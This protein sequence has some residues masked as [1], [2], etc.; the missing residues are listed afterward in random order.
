MKP[1]RARLLRMAAVLLSVAFSSLAL[2][3]VDDDRKA[4]EINK[5]ALSTGKDVAVSVLREIIS[6]DGAKQLAKGEMGVDAFKELL[7]G[8]IADH[9]RI[10]PLMTAVKTAAWW[11][12]VLAHGLSSMDRELQEDIYRWSGQQVGEILEKE[13]ERQYRR[14]VTVTVLNDILATSDRSLLSA[15]GQSANGPADELVKRVNER[16]AAYS[17]KIAWGKEGVGIYKKYAEEGWEGARNELAMKTTTALAEALFG[18]AGGNI[19]TAA[20]WSAAAVEFLGNLVLEYANQTKT[21]SIIGEIYGGW[22]GFA[23]YLVE[24][25]GINKQ[26]LLD[27]FKKRWESAQ[28]T[29][30]Y[31]GAFTGKSNDRAMLEFKVGVFKQLEAIHDSMKPKL[32]ALLEQERVAK[33]NAEEASAAQFQIK[34]EMNKVRQRQR[35][36]QERLSST[37]SSLQRASLS[38]A[39]NSAQ[40]PVTVIAQFPP[41]TLALA[42]VEF[43]PQSGGILADIE[44]SATLGELDLAAARGHKEVED[45]WNRFSIEFSKVNPQRAEDH[46]TYIQVSN[47]MAAAA[48]ACRN[49]SLYNKPSPGMKGDE[50]NAVY[51][52]NQEISASCLRAA[53]APAADLQKNAIA[54]RERRSAYWEAASAQRGAV[55]QAINSV[56][57]ST[58]TRIAGTANEIRTRAAGVIKRVA[59]LNQT[60]LIES[61]SYQTLATI[62]N[63]EASLARQETGEGDQYVGLPKLE[64]PKWGDP[65]LM[66]Y[67][68]RWQN[69]LGAASSS[70]SGAAGLDSMIKATVLIEGMQARADDLRTELETLKQLVQNEKRFAKEMPD[71]SKEQKAAEDTLAVFQRVKGKAS[72]WRSRY[73]KLRADTGKARDYVKDDL[74]WING[75]AARLRVV[76]ELLSGPAYKVEDATARGVKVQVM[77]KGDHWPHS[78][79]MIYTRAE[80]APFISQLTTLRNELVKWDQSY[81]VGVVKA[82]DAELARLGQL[83]AEPN[84]YNIRGGGNKEGNWILFPEDFTV[85]AAEVNG[86]ANDQDLASKL[87]DKFSKGP[88]G[89]SYDSLLTIG[90]W[91]E[92]KLQ[93]KTSFLSA[94]ASGAPNGPIKAAAGTLLKAINDKV[95]A[96]TSIQAT[97]YEK[98]KKDEDA[99]RARAEEEHKKQ[100]ECAQKGG[101]VLNGKCEVIAVPGGI[102]SGQGMGSPGGTAMGKPQGGTPSGGQMPAGP[103]QP[104][105]PMAGGPQQGS[106]AQGTS[107]QGGPPAGVQAPP[108]QQ[109]GSSPQAGLQGQ[110]PPTSGSPQTATAGPSVPGQGASGTQRMPAAAASAPGAAAA[111]PSGGPAQGAGQPP[112]A[113]PQSPTGGAPAQAGGQPPSGSGGTPQAMV[114]QRPSTATP[115][116]APTAPSG[117]SAPGAAPG[118]PTGPQAGVGGPQGAMAAQAQGSQTGTPGGAKP[119]GQP[120]AGA[121][122]PS[123]PLAAPPAGAAPAAKP[124]TAATAKPA[125]DKELEAQWKEMN[126]ADAKPPVS[127]GPTTAAARPGAA[128]A[129]AGAGAAA[130]S[131]AGTAVSPAPTQPAPAADATPAVRDLYQKFAEAYQRKDVRGM[132]KYLADQWQGPGGLSSHD[133][134]EGLAASFKTFDTIQLKMDGLQ[135][136]K[137]G[138]DS[139][140]V[141]YSASLSGRNSR[142]KAEDKVAVQ[143]VVKITTDGPRIV[144]SSGSL[145]LKIKEAAAAPGAAPAAPA[146]APADARPAVRELYQ[147]FAEA[148][149]RR[150]VRGITKYLAE[151]WQGPGGIASHE[152]EDELAASFKAFETVQLKIDGLQIQN[153]GTDS[154]NVGYTA[155]LSARRGAQKVDD[156]VA[157]QDVVRITAEGPRI[158]KTSGSIVVKSREAATAVGAPAAQAAPAAAADGADEPG[159]GRPAVRDLYQKFAD[160]YQRKDARS[161]AKY[162]ADQWQGPGGMS[163][164]DFEDGLASSFKTFDSIQFKI[165]GLQIQKTAADSFNV[166]YAAILNARSSK[167]N[168]KVD[169]R[170]NIQDVVKITAEGPRIVKTTGSLVMKPK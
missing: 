90:F 15:M 170:I 31:S 130:P 21:E 122:V 115:S 3:A 110:M 166:S 143:D 55:D 101:V 37:A 77:F 158:V 40:S 137:A 120:A 113:M 169:D 22:S 39:A 144:K 20:Q 85:L 160:A 148:Y 133:Y 154:F 126:K 42:A 46:P 33:R 96:F 13:A 68:E 7:K 5:A 16:M 75:I 9:D 106:P 17:G 19:I 114:A 135:I 141:S 104:G 119:A 6:K 159:K 10:K 129:G 67:V 62:E 66:P 25:P 140:N 34:T 44:K 124:A 149:Q 63:H 109:P 52:R 72:G 65:G 73:E 102:P 155:S 45:S 54:Y 59:A 156:K 11:D 49:P 168:L 153:A 108:G 53:G 64:F 83:F 121:Q 47:A 127:T 57:Q 163:T 48:E 116:G 43:S 150:D 32:N 125:V 131:R 81:N 151:Q 28:E 74:R 36:I 146:A 93:L 82:I 41:S 157:V 95:A 35:D 111:P 142:Q 87:A 79:E 136:Q 70:G 118:Q 134:E 26:Q 69:R 165:E 100:T 88:L 147:K 84:G 103:Q 107:A 51:M 162:L 138:A 132:T 139:Y 91:P 152:F 145:V 80:I 89:L 86:L 60:P 27:D 58:R 23:K 24:N 18:A 30:E 99:E 78:G 38:G 56:V 128:P 12:T 167:Q 117:A 50:I 71:I 4:S 164:Q 112:A 161:V 61:P 94:V 123:A 2:S 105:Q 76:G 1:D 98:K 97:A 14:Y 92:I 8:K 29:I